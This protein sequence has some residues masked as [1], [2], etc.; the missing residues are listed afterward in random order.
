MPRIWLKR[1]KGVRSWFDKAPYFLS[2]SMPMLLINH[3]HHPVDDVHM[4]RAM[5]FAINYKD[6]RELAVSGYSDPLK[7]GLILPFGLEQKFF[8]AEDT[9][10]YGT[11]FD[12]EQA[13]AE[14][15]AGGFT[16]VFGTDGELVETRDKNGQ[17]VPTMY[18]KSPDRLERLGVD[19]AHRREEHARRRHRRARALRRREL[20]L[21]RAVRRRLRPDHEHAVV[22]PFAVQAL[23]AL[24]SHHDDAGFRAAGRENVQE[25]GA[26]QRPQGARLHRAHRR[27]LG[28]DPHHQGRRAH[29]SLRIAS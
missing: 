27:A 5:A 7:P 22:G 11:W 8:S 24:R 1:E 14:L 9:K 3:K 2:S 19:R 21:E 23:V 16:P 13:K 17:K 10:K 28:A 20:V 4:R 6:I 12:P 18:I 29:C 15:K 26:F 25:H